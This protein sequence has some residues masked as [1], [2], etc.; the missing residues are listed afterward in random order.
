MKFASTN[1]NDLTLYQV[2]AY[3]SFFRLEELQTSDFRRLVLSQDSSKMNTFLLF[4]FDA[5][6]L[7][8]HLR[9]EWMTVY[10]Y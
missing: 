2:F 1:R 8:E 10:D 7:R 9:E 3:L 6:N 5:D 4:A